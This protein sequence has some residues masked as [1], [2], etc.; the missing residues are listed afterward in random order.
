MNGATAVVES[1]CAS[2]IRVCFANPGTSELHLVSALE[3]APGVR[4]VLCLF[5][6]VAT[7]AADG[8]GRMTG[9]PAVT[10]LHQG[11]GLA[12]GLAN[13]HNA[14]RAGSPVV[15]LVGDGATTHSALDAPLRSDITALARPMA[16]WVRTATSATTAGA[17]AAAAVAAATGPPG[18]TATLIVPADVAWSQGGRPAGPVALP[19][20]QASM[21]L[22]VDS[23]TVLL[24]GGPAL[25]APGLR[26][27]SRIAVATGA[28]ALVEAFPGRVEQGAGLPAIERLSA[29]P[30][31]A[32][33]RLAGCRRLVLAGARPPVAAF[34]EPGVP[35]ELA[36]SGC[37]VLR[38]EDDVVATLENLADPEVE[39]P[40]RR[41]ATVPSRQADSPL[42]AETVAETVAALLPD[43]AIVVDEANASG[44]ALPA[45]LA[46]A[47]RHDLL[48]N[49]GFAIGLGL[50]MAAG[51]ALACPDRPVI[52]LEADGS[53]MYTPSALWTHAR[54]GLDVTTIVLDNRGYAILRRAAGRM[55]AD[56]TTVSSKLFDLSGPEL[57]FIAL[58]TSLGVPAARAATTGELAIRLKQALADPGPHLID[59]SVP[60]RY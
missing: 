22:T 26:A 17:D 5:E 37:E 59:A 57:D 30:A 13:L 20:R 27:A 21:V 54:E 33:R 10:L 47:A 42:T 7:G 55:L 12:N 8:F 36:P 51:A 25:R 2:G 18:G 43:G 4:E 58:A 50:P 56:R 16:R 48:T 40:V 53:A 60:A 34:A 11:P 28:L 41:L 14:M 49:S 52:C 46:S 19:R 1:L 45:A 38:L 9:Q 3:Q 44:V 31:A 15:N 29:D 6:G 32:R 39:A 35:G 23:D 24:L